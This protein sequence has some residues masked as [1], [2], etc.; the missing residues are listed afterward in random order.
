[1]ISRYKKHDYL[2]VEY[3]IDPM[4]LYTLHTTTS[5]QVKDDPKDYN[6]P[7]FR[8]KFQLML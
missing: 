2:L 3:W 6:Y 7:I 5:V 1:M 8:N 4:Y